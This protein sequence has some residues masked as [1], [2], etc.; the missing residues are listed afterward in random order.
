MF[1]LQPRK[2]NLK[3]CHARAEEKRVIPGKKNYTV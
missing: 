2:A 1:S 3:F